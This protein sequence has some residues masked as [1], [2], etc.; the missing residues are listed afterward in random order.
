MFTFPVGFFGGSTGGGDPY[1]SNVILLITGNG[2]N[3]STTIPDVSSYA[4]SVTVFGNTQISTVQSKW[5]SS[6]ILFDGNNDYLYLPNSATGVMGTGD[7]TFELWVYPSS[8]S[9][10][11]VLIEY[12]R[13][14]V[15]PTAG[16]EFYVSTTG[17]KL[18]IYGGSTLNTLLIS[19]G[20]NIPVSSW[21]HIALTR[22][23]GSTKLFFNGVQSG[24]TTTDTTDYT[25]ATTWI[26]AY[27]GGSAS[28]SGYINDLR[29]TK[30]VARY[31]ANF[32][33][34]TAPFP[35]G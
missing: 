35:V 26:G 9:T 17:G 8:W 29:I 31:T 25:Q 1:W 6:S 19:S 13:Q 32:T 18:D 34:P 21:T 33:P 11:P 20:S 24:S 22:A 4:R 2:I 15:G 7:Y 28:L 5:S 12:G 23:S 3:G 16:I 27:I 14:S 10:T 30:G